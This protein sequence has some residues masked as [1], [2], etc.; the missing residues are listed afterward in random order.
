MKKIIF[1][2][3]VGIFIGLVI[4]WITYEGLHRTSND[5]FCVVCHEMR[6]MVSSYHQD[7]HGGSGK[8]GIKADC[9]TCH[10]PHDNVFNYIYTKAKNGIV[11]GKIHFFGDVDAIDWNANRENAR[12]HFVYDEGCLKCH[13][14]Y[15][16][17]KFI[18]K[19]GI[20]M[21]KHYASLLN[22]SKK[23]KC[24]S[25]HVGV[26]H[27]GLR[28]TLNYYKPEYEYYKGKFKEEK[29]KLETALDKELAR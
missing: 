27:A 26:G 8:S 3:F 10:M 22:T 28:N 25:C 2:G 17:N 19:Q 9:I 7:V 13:S 18:S 23:I 29:E 5:K 12:E 11:E 16:T 14:N 24:A 21:H 20:K 15:L 1:I 4:S 6:P